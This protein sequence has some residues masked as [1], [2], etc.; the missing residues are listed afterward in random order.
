MW[1]RTSLPF[2][3]RQ[4]SGLTLVEVLVGLVLVGIV[5][6]V[7]TAFSMGI[8]TAW[9]EERN[10]IGAQETLRAVLD[11]LVRDI[12]LAGACLPTVGSAIPLALRGTDGA[13]GAPDSVTMH[14][15]ITCVQTVLDDDVSSG[16]D[17]LEV[18]SATGFNPGMVAFI[19]H[20]SGSPGEYVAITDVD[21]GDNEI[22]VVPG[23]ASSGGVS[24]AYP[25]GSG[26]YRAERRAY[27]VNTTTSPPQ[28]ML[29]IECN[30]AVPY[31]AG[32]EDLQIL[33][34][35][36]NDIWYA[37]NDINCNTGNDVDTNND[38]VP[39]TT[40][41]A[42]DADWRQVIQVQVTVTAQSSRTGRGGDYRQTGTV[43]I[44]PRNLLR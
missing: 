18:A 31:A 6:V 21:T 30:P 4:V 32:I 17:E 43:F 20:T 7:V 28:L 9:A 24:N 22:E 36:R 25:T 37:A 33:Y 35:C 41:T 14:S 16:E 27:S 10:R 1:W 40:G 23:C 34:Q 39:D 3:R 42:T 8:Y 44:K 26:V 11:T 13:S 5:V 38:G 15:N 19:Q 12:R 2:E 29:G